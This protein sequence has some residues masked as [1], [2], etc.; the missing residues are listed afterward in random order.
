MAITQEMLEATAAIFADYR[1]GEISRP[2]AVHVQTWLNQFD[3]GVRE[4]LLL[5]ITHVLQRTYVSR[6]NVE[7]FLAGLVTNKKLAGE[8]P[9]AFWKGVKFLDIQ[10][11]GRSQKEFLR[12]FAI[13]LKQ[14]AGLEL[15]ECGQQPACYVYLDDGIFTGMTLIQSM[16]DWLKKDAPEKLTVHIIVIAGHALGKHYAETELKKIAAAAK[17][18]VDFHWWALLGLEDRKINIYNSD[19]LR[20]TK[21]PEDEAVKA[22]VESMRFKPVLRNP[23]SVGEKKFFSSEAGRDLLEQQF[24][25]KGAHIRK[26]APMLPKYARPLGDMVLETLGFG[27]TFVTFRN[28]PNNTPLAFWAGNP[29]YPLFPRKTN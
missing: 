29:W 27:S 19:V 26:I 9:A 10:G 14:L 8:T 28:C 15:A 12:L 17:K 3:E 24:L 25:I 6:T 1:D 21:I 20:P 11:R 5:E 4:Q 7:K 18:S 2:N 22:Y 13:P 23:G 16:G